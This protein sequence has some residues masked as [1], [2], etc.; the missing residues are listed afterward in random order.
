MTMSTMTPYR[1]ALPAGRDSFAQ[2]LHAEWTKF[3]SV[4][5]WVLGLVAV[6]VLT[7]LATVA[8]AAAAQ[9]NNSPPPA[10]TGPAGEGV[11]DSFYFVHQPVAAN[12]AIT[13]QVTSLTTKAYGGPGASSITPAWAKAGIIVKQSTK[14]GS[15]YVAIMATPGHGV[16]MQYNFTGD[17]AGL[18]GAVTAASPRWLRLA[19]AGD[20]ITGYD[21]SDGTHWTKVGT[22]RLS[23]LPSTV[24]AGLFVAS[25]LVLQSH[26]TFANNGGVS[27]PTLATAT[28]RHFIVRGG[29]SGTSPH[30]SAIGAALRAQAHIPPG[31]S[32][33]ACQ[34]H[35]CKSILAL[36][37]DSVRQ[38][39]GTFTVAGS[40][41]IAPY[42]AIVDPTGTAFK[43][44][45]F[46]LLAAIAVGA[47]FVTT[48][49]RRGLI[50][51]TLTSSPRRGR[52]LVAK[53]IV[54]G[55]VTFVAALI[56]AA[57]AFPIVEQQLRSNGWKAPVYH[58]ISLTS[59]TG[60][61]VV[62]GTAALFAVAAI[63]ALAAGS[64]LRRSA[65]AIA[66]VI[67]LVILPLILGIVLPLTPAR[68]I[69]RLTPAAA[70]GLQ[71]ANPRYPQVASACLP[72]NG[73]YPLAPWA[74]FAVM[75]AWALIAMTVAVF[76]LRGKDA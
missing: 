31:G 66:A 53:A 21:S 42:Q 54:I 23:G 74:G 35:R 32:I 67:V 27:F 55:A 47:L 7:A 16:R 29:P 26:Q 34:G 59:G 5:G 73:C 6:A 68:W 69:L 19:R 39:G 64:A 24:Q 22:V 17:T 28:F 45:L 38:S 49:Y 76:L 52:V 63:L 71:Q 51:T 56:G 65:G 36:P 41:D 33:S 20:T 4:H 12:A 9:D 50:R 10:V 14:P 57:V 25:P 18:P 62:V 1:S 70:F 40:G 8:L 72:Y 15:P 61:R 13:V 3:R 60:V 58:V 48:E 30:G 44:V 11:T 2:V 46:G 37:P 43:G 75:C